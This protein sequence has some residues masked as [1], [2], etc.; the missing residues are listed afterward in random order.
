[1]FWLQFLSKLIRVLREGDSPRA[2]A[3]GFTVGFFLGLTP[4]FTLQNF[5]L[6]LV[7]AL[8][9]VNLAAVGFGTLIFGFVSYLFDPIFHSIGY[10]LLVRVQFLQGFYIFLYNLPVAPMT[11]F[12]NTI[13]AGSTAVG[14][15]LSPLV[16]WL[17]KRGVESYRARWGERIEKS[18]LVRYL[19]GTKLVQ[20]Y[21]KLRDL[22]F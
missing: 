13:V 6:L 4:F 14:I 16:F 19:Q 17:S 21:V 20:W 1:M 22:R 3:G 2:I 8:L 5:V 12:Y 10:F 11:R 9:R 7:A 15:A 18:R